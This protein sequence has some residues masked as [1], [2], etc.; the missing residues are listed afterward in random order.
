MQKRLLG[1]KEK[2][3]FV[4]PTTRTYVQGDIVDEKRKHWNHQE[5]VN[6]KDRHGVLGKE[7]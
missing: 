1:M 5:G 3:Y 2:R 6:F 7:V 4:D